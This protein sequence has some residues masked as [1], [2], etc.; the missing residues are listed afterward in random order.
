[1]TTAHATYEGGLLNLHDD[2]CQDELNLRILQTFAESFLV[3][4]EMTQ[5]PTS[6][7]LIE[8]DLAPHPVQPDFLRYD[9]RIHR[10]TDEV[11]TMSGYIDHPL[12]PFTERPEAPDAVD[13]AEGCRE[14]SDR[15]REGSQSHEAPRQQGPSE[16]DSRSFE[17]PPG[18]P[19]RPPWN[20]R[21]T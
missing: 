3:C 18:P 13:V 15:G 16:G 9:V 14:R 17:R 4:W 10:A 20:Q 11:T 8:F 12:C 5:G 6:E 21:L 2:L 7:A 1:M 19:H